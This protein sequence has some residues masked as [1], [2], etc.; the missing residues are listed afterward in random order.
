MGNGQRASV[1]SRPE[2]VGFAQKQYCNPDGGFVAPL[3][4]ASAGLGDRYHYIPVT[5]WPKSRLCSVHGGDAW[6]EACL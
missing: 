5:T 4:I 3:C 1:D 2:A 6:A